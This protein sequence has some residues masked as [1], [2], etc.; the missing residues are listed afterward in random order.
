MKAIFFLILATVQ[1]TMAQSL[2]DSN[3]FRDFA[4]IQKWTPFT[5]TQ[6]KC[7]NENLEFNQSMSFFCS[8]DQSQ[9]SPKY[10]K[11]LE[12]EKKYLDAWKAYR[13]SSNPEDRALAIVEMQNADFD[14]NVF[15]NGGVYQ[16]LN[17]IS[18]STNHCNQQ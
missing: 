7:L 3:C 1:I 13:A 4:S 11:F 9:L 15:G 10:S 12:L 14:M 18:S 2:F 5:P 16:N 6:I 17:S 8:S